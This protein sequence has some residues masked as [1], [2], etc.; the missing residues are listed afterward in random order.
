[1]KLAVII[2]MYNDDQMVKNLLNKLSKFHEIDEII[3]SKAIDNFKEHSITEKKYNNI[4]YKELIS[5]KGRSIQMNNAIKY[6]NCDILWFIHSDSE[7]INYDIDKKIKVLIKNSKVECGG[8]K[9]KFSPNSPCLS[10]IAYLSNLRAKI[11]KICF[12]DQSIFV[13]K[14]LFVKING[15]RNIPIMEDLQFFLDIKKY[16]NNTNYFKLLNENIISSSRRFKKNGILKTIF[17]M[18]KLKILYFKGVDPIKLNKI[19]NNMKDR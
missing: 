7:F 9:I 6:T 3:I 2:P 14:E 15:F 19:Y 10:I 5:E 13:T 4:T 1:M 8:L 17:K 11:F 12:G 16:K 18:H